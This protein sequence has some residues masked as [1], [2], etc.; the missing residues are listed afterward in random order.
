MVSRDESFCLVIAII[1]LSYL[2]AT[3][4][5]LLNHHIHLLHSKIVKFGELTCAI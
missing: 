3:K 4:L 2:H 5:S 1:M